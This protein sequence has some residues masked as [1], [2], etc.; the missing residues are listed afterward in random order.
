MGINKKYSGYKSYQ[1][2][3]RGKDYKEFKLA[4]EIGRVELYDV[5]LTAAEEKRVKAIAGKCVVISLHDHP[6]VL[7]EDMAQLF[8]YNN[9]GRYCTAYEGLSTSCLD[10]VFDGLMAA[11]CTITSKRGWK[12]TDVI[13]DL[14]IRLSDL[15]HQDFLIKCERVDDILTAHR[16]GKIALAPSLESCT[17]IENELDRIDILYGLGVRMMGLVYSESNSLGSGLREEKDGG[18]TYFGLEAIARMN[19]IGMAIDL[20]HCGEQTAMD[21]IGASKSPV[22]ITHTGTRSLWEAKRLK[23]DSVLRLCADK[24]GIVGIEAAPHTTITR[25]NP[26]HGIESFMEHFEYVKDLVGI[27]HVGF[28]PDTTYGDHVALHHAFASLL[29]IKQ[30]STPDKAVKYVKGLENPSEAS[31]NIIRWLVKHGYS[32]VEIEK[33]VGGNA[34][35]V[36]RTIW[37]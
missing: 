18:L 33:V 32:D 23:T 4:K 14:G 13:C 8:E 25:K 12:W 7:T 1:F 36:L 17:M 34:L 6:V 9:Q 21:A 35:R 11:S 28:G 10:G 26:E 3:E 31:W 20:S 15:S 27:D 19:K 29:S 22:F 30:T 16:E 2:L 37:V 5:P 24:G